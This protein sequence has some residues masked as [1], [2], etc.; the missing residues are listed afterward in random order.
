MTHDTPA[1][2]VVQGFG[3]APQ[4]QLLDV[5][6]RSTRASCLD[7][8]QRMLQQSLEAEVTAGIGERYAERTDGT[9]DWVC[10]ECGS[11]N[12]RQFRRNGH[13][14]RSLTVR[15][16]TV[17]LCM[18]LV[19]CQ[20]NGYVDVPWQTVEP[21]ARYWLDVDLDGIRRYVGGMSYRLVGDAV[22]TQAQTNISHVQAWRTM[23]EAGVQG[24]QAV[25]SLGACPQSVVLDEAYITV[26]GETAVFLIAVAD[27]GRV[28]AVWGPTD[29]TRD[30]WQALI[31]WLTECGISP[32]QGL[33]GVISDGDS[34][35]RGAVQLVWPRVV[36]QQCVWHILERVADDVAAVY[37]AHAPEVQGIVEQAGRIFLHDVERPDAQARAKQ[38]LAEFVEQHRRTAWAE[39]VVR[40]FEEATE[41]LRTPG[42]QRTN[43]LAERTIKELRRRTK[44]MDGFKSEDGA[45]HFAE[46]WRA[47]KNLRLEMNR[48]RARRV[49]HRRQDLKIRQPYPKLA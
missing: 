17:H 34:A 30:S 15:H 20:C 27:D 26:G 33:K 36:L 10:R 47:W 25:A 6:E 24:K 43:G 8:T 13:Y 3:Q 49:C 19:R 11:R 12:R 23:Q 7:I 21:R 4:H 41:Y 16:G 9:I 35:I 5:I 32:L 29:R 46:V 37:G 2:F 45:A 31:E 48:A 28:L 38:R 1:S 14:R 42:L 40:T 18:P 39:T 22:S 44:T